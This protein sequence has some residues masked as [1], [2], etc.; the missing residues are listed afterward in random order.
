MGISSDGQ[1]CFGIDFGE[2]YEF[3][4]IDED[5]ESDIDDWW[6]E[7][8][9]Y[10]PLYTD[11]WDE[12]GNYGE[13]YTEEKWQEEYNRKREWDKQNPL[14]VEF[15]YYC[16]YDYPMHILSIPSTRIHCCRGEAVEVT[17]LKIDDSWR[18]ILK[19]FCDTYNIKFEEPK[20]WLTSMYG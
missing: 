7:V 14:P 9:G 18:G 13:G 19:D 4:W 11:L 1:L 8:N 15:C 20:W 12:N 6:R 10:K 16:S 17:N 5:G 3:P 2:E